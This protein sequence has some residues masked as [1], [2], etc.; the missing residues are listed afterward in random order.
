MRMIALASAGLLVIGCATEAPLLFRP[1]DAT[2]FSSLEQRETTEQVSR[3]KCAGRAHAALATIP[4]PTPPS[5]EPASITVN[6]TTVQNSV[7]VTGAPKGIQLPEVKYGR[8][9]SDSYARGYEQGAYQR[10]VE[11]RSAAGDAAFF[12]C[13]AEEGWVRTQ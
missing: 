6:R 3:A 5:P 2:Q 13:M 7:I 1:I 10:A 11:E 8:S 12:A 4:Q 9:V